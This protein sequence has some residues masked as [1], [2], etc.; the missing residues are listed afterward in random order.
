MCLTQSTI[1]LAD[2]KISFSNKGS[3]TIFDLVWEN[4]YPQSWMAIGLNNDPQMVCKIFYIVSN[5]YLTKFAVVSHTAILYFIP[6]LYQI[7]NL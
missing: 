1:T 4:N 7:E 6:F 2:I 5:E 3:F